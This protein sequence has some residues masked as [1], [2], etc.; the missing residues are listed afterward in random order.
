MYAY[1]YIYIYI[2]T[3]ICESGG[4]NP[5]TQRHHRQADTC[6]YA[7]THSYL[8]CLYAQK[9]VSKHRPELS[10]IEVDR[11]ASVIVATAA[12]KRDSE[13]SGKEN[14]PKRSHNGVSR[15]GKAHSSD[16]GMGDAVSYKREA[17]GDEVEADRAP[18][19]QT[20]IPAQLVLASQQHSHI[21]HGAAQLCSQQK[22]IIKPSA[23]ST[24][25]SQQRSLAAPAFAGVS[26][27]LMSRQDQE[28]SRTDSPA[29]T[30]VQGTLPQALPG[31][32]QPVSIK[33]EEATCTVHGASAPQ[34]RDSEQQSLVKQC[35][36]VAPNVMHALAVAGQQDTKEC[37]QED[38]TD[39]NRDV[40]P[41]LNATS[42]S[43]VSFGASR[44]VPLVHVIDLTRDEDDV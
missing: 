13:S 5:R 15:G 20:R 3:F 11:Y 39:T 42:S 18:Q 34:Q 9:L 25:A 37:K 22:S 40:N 24:Q 14:S 6:I 32:Q 1:I 7:R 29:S 23:G 36:D 10:P 31:R 12:A 21:R 4:D 27:A 35:T 30:V 33:R 8:S 16:H 17:D 41:G 2:H 38:V 28:A 43:A 26:Q 44:R 19:N